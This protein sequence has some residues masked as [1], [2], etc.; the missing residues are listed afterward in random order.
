MD[1]KSKNGRSP[2]HTACLHG[3]LRAVQLM[4]SCQSQP[5]AYLSQRDSCGATPIMDAVR[6]GHQDLVD[7]LAQLC[8]GSLETLDVMSRNC[9][10]T[11]AHSGHTG[12]I[13]HLVTE[14][15]MD[16]NGSS[17]TT[18][19]HWAAKEGQCG[20]IKVLLELG[21]N[22]EKCDASGRTPVALAIGGQHVEST[23]ILIAHNS[24]TPFDT[25]LLDLART[26]AM[27][28]CLVEA[29]LNLWNI[30]LFLPGTH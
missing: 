20:A 11:A 2:L 7:Y 24:L 17:S 16:P 29:F 26:D 18:P 27:K 6:G 8:P 9:L 5:L 30:V 15:C 14:H 19:L 10:H 12:L 4:L 1:S 13:K 21:A 22:P 23:R 28:K 3:H 25:R